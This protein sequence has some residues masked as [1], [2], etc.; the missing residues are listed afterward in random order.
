[1]PHL[2][3]TANLARH[4]P[5]PET[6]LPAATVAQLFDAYFAHWPEVRGYVL[7]DQGAVCKHTMILVD[8]L[9]LRDRRRLGDALT[10]DSTVYV[11][12]ALSGG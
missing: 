4:T 2:I 3:F 12:Q 1:M 6:D 8:G 5:C 10:H 7:D 9:N 11:F